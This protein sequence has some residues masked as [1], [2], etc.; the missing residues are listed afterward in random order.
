MCHILLI[1]RGLHRH[2]LLRSLTKHNRAH[3][4]AVNCVK[5]TLST[6]T[7]LQHSQSEDVEKHICWICQEEL[8]REALLVEH[9]D[10]HMTSVYIFT[11]L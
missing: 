2:S 3:K 7:S 6:Q 1:S 5:D 9:Y 4:G 10:N 11:S 8:C